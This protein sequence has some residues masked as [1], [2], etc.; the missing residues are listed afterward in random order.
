MPAEQPQV[1]DSPATCVGIQQEVA[2]ADAT[3]FYLQNVAST[4]F[5]RWEDLKREGNKHVESIILA[6]EQLPKLKPRITALKERSNEIVACSDDF[7]TLIDTTNDLVDEINKISTVIIPAMR[8]LVSLLSIQ[9]NEIQSLQ[10]QAPSRSNTPA[11]DSE[12]SSVQQ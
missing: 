9:A 2:L 6:G 8:K 1:M 7:T 4:V 12:E 10:N 11:D 5:S 3:V